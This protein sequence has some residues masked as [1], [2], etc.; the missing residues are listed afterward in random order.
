V[1]DRRWQSALGHRGGTPALGLSEQGW[2]DELFQ[3]MDKGH[4]AGSDGNQVARDQG[5]CGVDPATVDQ[6]AI[7]GAQVANPP[8]SLLKKDFRVPSAG[9]FVSD[10]D[11]IGGG[12]S[13]D[14]TPTLFQ[15]KY[16][17]PAISLANNQVSRRAVWLHRIMRRNTLDEM[18]R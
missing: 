13:H 4:L 10:R 6:G 14:Q 12:A 17:R 11:R 2:R 5:C 9:P 16:V 3:G 18:V 8:A 15:S 7:A 1:S